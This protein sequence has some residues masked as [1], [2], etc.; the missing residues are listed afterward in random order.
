MRNVPA[1]RV[2]G[3]YRAGADSTG[4]QAQYGAGTVCDMSPIYSHACIL[5]PRNVPPENFLTV[6]ELQGARRTGVRRCVM[7]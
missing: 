2:T 4:V 3:G 6:P 5:V 7:V 1:V